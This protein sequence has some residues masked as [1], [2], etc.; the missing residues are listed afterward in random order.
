M[1]ILAIYIAKPSILTYT[2]WLYRM[3]E[4]YKQKQLMRLIFWNLGSL[5]LWLYHLER[6]LCRAKV[7][8][9]SVTWL[10]GFLWK[11]VMEGAREKL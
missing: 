7:M 5:T 4:N 2:L 1:F 6:T 11:A 10:G 8:V 9:E 3:L